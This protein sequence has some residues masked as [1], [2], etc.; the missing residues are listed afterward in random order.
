[1]CR[2]FLVTKKIYN[3]TAKYD[4]NIRIHFSIVEQILLV[5]DPTSCYNV[6]LISYMR[7]ASHASHFPPIMY[8]YLK[9]ES[10]C[11]AELLHTYHV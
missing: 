9:R 3:F 11:V 2:N 4:L 8:T 1:M 10:P 5:S 7:K 6:Q